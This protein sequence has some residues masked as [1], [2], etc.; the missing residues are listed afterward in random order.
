MAAMDYEKALQ[1]FGLA[2]F[3]PGQREV[4]SQ[5]VAGHDCLC[6]MPT[7]GGK[8]LCFQ[9]PTILRPG[10]TIVVSPLIA[11]MKDQVDTLKRRGIAATLI[12]STLSNTEQQSRLGE[13]AAGKF[14]LLYV[15]PERLRNPR[16][17]EA[18]RATPVQLLAVDEAHCISEWGHDFRPDYA[19]LGLFREA[20][21]G[22]QTVALTATATPRVRQDIC[23]ILQLRQPRQFITG[24]A[25]SNLHLGAVYCSS[26]RDKDMALIEFLR[27]SPGTGIIY[28]AT[29]KR[30][31]SLVETISQQLR[32]SV[33]AYHAGLTL[34]QRK[35]IQEQFMEGK[36]QAIVA[37]N[38]FGMGIDKADLRYVIHYNIPGSMEA[39]Y[40]EAGRAG[41]DGLPSQCVVLYSPQDRYIQEFFIENA[42][43]PPELIAK[44]YELLGQ[45]TGD[46][47]EKTAQELKE[48][49]DVPQS[50][51]AVGTALQILAKTGVIERLEMSGGLAMV[52][53]QS[54]LPTM[55][56]MLPK[57]AHLKRQVLRAV[58]R[59]VAD[60]REEAVYLHPRWLMQ[61]TGLDREAV[62]R[63]LGELRK[64]PGF[65]YVPPFR[66][67][68][69]HIRQRDLPFEQLGIDFA[70]LEARKQ[71]DLEKLEQVVA[72]A[73]SKRCRQLSILQYFGDPEARACGRCDRCQGTAGWP[74][75]PAVAKPMPAGTAEAGGNCL[76]D[77]PL[78]AGEGAAEAK[79]SEPSPA[80]LP[81]TNMGTASPEKTAVPE[82]GRRMLVRRIIE[83]VARHR[84]LCG[85]LLLVDFLCGAKTEKVE[86][87][88]LYR[89]EGYGLLSQH[90]KGNVSHLLEMMLTTG[91]LESQMRVARR[92][93]IVV[94]TLGERIIAGELP[95]PDQ[96]EQ[97]LQAF[98]AAGEP[99]RGSLSPAKT[100]SPPVMIENRRQGD[101]TSTDWQW[102]VS[103]VG[104]DYT[105][106]EI[107]AIRRKSIDEVIEDLAAAAAQGV[108]ISPH[109]LFD[110]PTADAFRQVRLDSPAAEKLPVFLQRPALWRLARALSG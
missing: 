18:I 108:P 78:V 6:V 51:E 87:L 57:E 91:M 24:F 28:A 29:R 37:T 25:R 38:A 49:L 26:D 9:L 39:Y 23:E 44:V 33:G 13:V 77:N 16:F 61:Q 104:H 81:T 109:Q 67:R 46:P 31:E 1:R 83:A 27:Q 76:A 2:S 60:R 40:Q 36:L 66:G 47:I 52:R 42:N 58:E 101:Q 102:T 53:I 63:A 64:L 103:L 45:L 3:R 21:G 97:A 17:L 99:E 73:Q 22:V 7:G 43:P 12:N 85:K 68:A 75:M 96:V 14:N 107:A 55:V 88:R 89:I 32:I 19:R 5:I 82:P 15:A 93:T 65:E 30:C 11:L 10:L 8:S 56:E 79:T 110:A 59:G 100:S 74:R 20:L 106:A 4:I 48:L 84:G 94:S 69:I 70:A 72:F 62:G 105:L 54:Q 92:P 98:P 90:K 50:A 86:R 34:D 80:S 35:F 41:R 95:L 71:S